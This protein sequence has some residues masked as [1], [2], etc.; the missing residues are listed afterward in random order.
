MYF[1]LEIP[2][3]PAPPSLIIHYPNVNSQ[4][5]LEMELITQCTLSEFKDDWGELQ[6]KLLPHF[7]ELEGEDNENADMPG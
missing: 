3:P 7:K 1:W 6:Q 4:L 2:P 5:Q